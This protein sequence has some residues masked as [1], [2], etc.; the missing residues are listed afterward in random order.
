MCNCGVAIRESSLNHNSNLNTY[1][2]NPLAFKR[3]EQLL[4]SSGRRTNHSDSL[5]K[6]KEA[7]ACVNILMRANTTAER[8]VHV[9]PNTNTFST[10]S[11]ILITMIIIHSIYRCLSKH[12]R[13]R[14]IKQETA[15]DIIV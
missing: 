13:H 5:V 11:L 2:F 14:T 7:N 3:T 12:R 15:R 1:L 10:H 4:Q 6:V 9:T 8:E